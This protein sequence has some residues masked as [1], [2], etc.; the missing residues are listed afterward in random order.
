ML[1]HDGHQFECI[2]I[3]E[4]QMHLTLCVCLLFDTQ[5]IEVDEED[6]VARA[7]ATRW[8]RTAMTALSQGGAG[9]QCR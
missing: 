1:C 9:R 6:K 8:K 2:G 7:K 3:N 5:D 4:L